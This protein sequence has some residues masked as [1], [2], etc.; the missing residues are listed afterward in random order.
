[1][2]AR[3]SVPLVYHAVHPGKTLNSAA[4]L[5]ARVQIPVPPSATSRLYTSCSVG[6]VWGLWWFP[7]FELHV[8]SSMWIEAEAPSE[9]GVVPE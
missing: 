6:C 8:Y 5:P 9:H 2:C 1:M 7:P 4:G 3:D